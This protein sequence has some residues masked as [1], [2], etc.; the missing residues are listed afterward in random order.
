M[1]DHAVLGQFDLG[2]EID[3][4]QPG[5]D[6]S[7]REPRQVHGP[8]GMPIWGE[9]FFGDAQPGRDDLEQVRA[10][11]IDALVEHLQTLQRDPAGP[12]D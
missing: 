7:G 1:S 9:E 6:L 11:L 10:R 2:E 12:V 4:F 3:R 5:E 8:R